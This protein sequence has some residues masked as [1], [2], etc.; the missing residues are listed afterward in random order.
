MTFTINPLQ[1]MVITYSHAKVQGQRSVSSEDRVET[2]GWTDRRMQAIALPVALL[3][4]V[5]VKLQRN[6]MASD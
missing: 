4:S 5:K 2:N 3:W 1:A 6:K